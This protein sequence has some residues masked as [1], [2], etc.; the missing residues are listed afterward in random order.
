MLTAAIASSDPK[1]SARLLASLEQSGLVGSIKQ[2]LMPMEKLPDSNDQVPDIVFLDLSHDHDAFFSFGT[3]LRRIHP[4]TK[5]IAC[6]ATVPPS[7]Q[8]LLQAMRGGVQDFLPKPVDPE[9]LKTILAR[10]LQ[11][12]EGKDRPSFNKL[13]VIMGSKG[14]VGST[15]VAVNLGVKLA[16]HAKKRALVLDFARP[17]GNVHLL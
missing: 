17:L 2:W 16:T 5:I 12:S 6:S 10:V 1:S 8:L 9:A 7:P 13:V 15:T 4:A 3:Q 14:G 11:E